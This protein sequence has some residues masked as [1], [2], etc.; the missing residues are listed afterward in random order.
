MKIT[1][2]TDSSKN[3]YIGYV[4]RID[5]E[6]TFSKDNINNGRNVIIFGVHESSLV[7]ANNKA[8]NMLWV[9]FLYKELTI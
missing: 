6:G 3:I 9:N 5:E 7:H 2:N 4:L 8:N 1:E